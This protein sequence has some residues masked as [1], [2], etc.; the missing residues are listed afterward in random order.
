MPNYLL[1]QL[2]DIA[3]QRCPC[4]LTRRAFASPDN[5]T[6]TVHLLDVQSDAQKHYHKTLTEIYLILEGTGQMEL[7]DQIVPVKPL[8][9]LMIK[10]GCRHRAIGKL[11]IAIIPIPAFDPADEWFD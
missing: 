7:D 2:D 11:R 6:A 1:T 4:G 9:A 10:P 5:P 8:T 3:T